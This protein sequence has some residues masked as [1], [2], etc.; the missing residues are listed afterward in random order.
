MLDS[1]LAYLQYEKRYSNHTLVAYKNDLA[2]F[3]A[4]LNQEFHNTDLLSADFLKIR[5]WIFHLAEHEINSRS[6]NRKIACLRSFYGFALRKAAISQDPTL[7]I[8]APKVKKALPV[9]VEETS[10]E[11]LWDE[12]PFPEGFAG[13]RDR[14]VL[15][16]LYGTG[17]RLAELTALQVQDID[18]PKGVL[19]VLGKGNKERFVPLNKALIN[20]LLV[21]IQQKNQND[22]GNPRPWLIVTDN[23]DRAYPMFIYRVVRTYLDM[24]TTVDKRSP[25]V[26]RHSFATHLLNHGADLNAIKEMLGHANLAATQVYTHNSVEK[27]RAVFEKAHPKA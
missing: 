14:I 3:Q 5:S 18:F 20:N 6:I 7:K 13:I 11:K 27:L 21:Y 10:L 9:Y 25:H 16:L 8:K 2:Q 1:F 4:F 17:M 24:V 15:E 12:L 19:K 22:K 26:L 23:G